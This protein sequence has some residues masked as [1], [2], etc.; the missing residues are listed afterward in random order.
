[1]DVPSKRDWFR[2]RKSSLRRRRT[3][4][5]RA[6]LRPRRPFAL[7]LRSTRDGAGE[8]QLPTGL[9]IDNQDRIYIVDSFN[10]RFR[11]FATTGSPK[12]RKRGASEEN[13][14]TSPPGMM[15]KW[16]VEGA[17]HRAKARIFQVL[18]GT[19]KAVPYPKPIYETHSVM[20]SIIMIAMVMVF[21]HGFAAAQTPVN[22]DVLGMHN[23]TAASGASVYP[24]EVWAHFLSR[25]A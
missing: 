2:F 22:A 12:R 17:S 1:M 24:R 23:L 25:S 19:P 13:P 7:L 16:R 5:H 21:L 14:V 10:R 6:G 15:R 3:V 4:G 18:N 8:F 9:Q 11:Y 20:I